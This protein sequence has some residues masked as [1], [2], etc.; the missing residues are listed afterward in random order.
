MHPDHLAVT[1]AD[2]VGVV[3]IDLD[4]HVLLQ[5][6]NPR[7]GAGKCSMGALRRRI[8]ATN[9]RAGARQLTL[10]FRGL[11]EQARNAV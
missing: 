9:P 11:V 8:S 5:L 1:H 3:R 6:G 4:E 7:V 10:C 2:V